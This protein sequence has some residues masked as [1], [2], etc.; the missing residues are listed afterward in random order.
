M[1]EMKRSFT[2]GK[3]N[4]DLDERLVPNGEYRDAMNVQV[5]TSEGSDV[6]TVQNV[7]GNVPGC[8]VDLTPNNSYTVGSVADEKNDTLYWLVSGNSGFAPEMKDMILRRKPDLVNGGYTCEPV[9]V[10]K[11]AFT[12]PNSENTDLDSLTVYAPG[13]LVNQVY[14]GWTATGV[15][16][17][18]NLSN[19]VTI[20]DVI[21]GGNYGFN[22]TFTTSNTPTYNSWCVGATVNPLI[23]CGAS[24]TYIPMIPAFGGGFFLDTSSGV[25]IANYTGD[26]LSGGFID[27]DTPGLGGNG[28]FGTGGNTYGYQ[29]TGENVSGIVVGGVGTPVVQLTLDAPLDLNP[30]LQGN[31]PASFIDDAGQ[32]WFVVD[33]SNITEATPNFATIPNSGII[34][35]PNIPLNVLNNMNIGDPVVLD[36]N[37]PYEFSGCINAVD[38]TI[39]PATIQ[40]VDCDNPAIFAEPAVLIPYPM[41]TYA[42]IGNIQLGNQVTFDF[43]QVD[44]L[45]SGDTYDSIVL[46]GPRVLNYDHDNLILGVNIIDDFLFW[47]DNKTEPKK[48]NIPRSVAGTDPS[49]NVHTDVM[50]PDASDNIT[51]NRGP[52]REQHITVIKKAP[53]RPPSLKM[54]TEL[55]GGNPTGE[56]YRLQYVGGNIFSAVGEVLFVKINDVDGIPCDFVVGDILGVNDGTNAVEG[57]EFADGY[58]VRLK[59]LEVHTGPYTNVNPGGPYG[60]N[61]FPQGPSLLGETAYLV[62]IVSII[63]DGS[64]SLAGPLEGWYVQLQ[65]DGKFLFEHKMPRF[66]YRYKYVD[67][68]YSTY[69]PFSNVAFAGGAFEYQPVKAY[70]EGMS[71]K[72]RALTIQDFVPSDIPEDV[73]QVDI[74]YKNENSPI[75][76]LM[77]SIKELDTP[78]LNNAWYATGS[79]GVA[80]AAKG[81]YEITTEN[82]YAALPANQLLRTWDNVP[83]TALAQDIT[84][85]RIVYGNY[86]QGYSMQ[87]IEVGGN[88]IPDINVSLSERNVIEGE[89]AVKSIKSLRNYDIGV[90]WGDKYGRET[91]VITPSS[92]S[93]V[94]PKVEASSKNYLVAS[95]EKS[96]AWADYYRYYI[97]ETSN[98]YYNLAVDRIYDA[99]DGNIWVSFPSID[100]NKVDED[101][102]IILKK[103]SD[104]DD[105]VEEKA[106]YKIVAIENEAPEYI[107]T[108]FEILAR[109]NTDTTTYEYSCQLFGGQLNLAANGNAGSDGAGNGCPIYPNPLGHITP[110]R[111]GRKSFTIDKKHWTD[112]YSNSPKRMGLPD[113][114]KVFEDVNADNTSDE[115]F[116]SFTKETST[117]G[118]TTTII[119]G[120]KYRV[121][122]IITHEG[123]PGTGDDGDANLGTTTINFDN[124]PL[125]PGGTA[126]DTDVY[127][128][129]LSTPI[130]TTDEFV[131]EGYNSVT[132]HL[133]PDFIHIH[134]WKKSIRNKPEFDG[135]FFVKIY[136]DGN[137]RKNLQQTPDAVKNWAIAASTSLFK[138]DD[139]TN[140]ADVADD[141]FNFNTGLTSDTAT[142]AQWGE[143]LKFG[144]ANVTSNWFIDNASFASQQPNTNNDFSNVV[145]L[146]TD[147]AGT[148]HES[149]DTTSSVSYNMVST[150]AFGGLGNTVG[151]GNL[152]S[153]GITPL[154]FGTGESTGIVGT[155]GAHTTSGGLYK[156][157]DFSYSSFDQSPPSLAQGLQG[158]TYNTNLNWAIGELGQNAATDDE[159]P[160]VE[161]L[162]PNV[163]FRLAGAETIYKIIG[164][165]K[166]RLFN[167]QG[168]KT[169][170]PASSSPG[171]YWNSAHMQQMQDMA[172]KTNRRYTFRIHYD[173]DT[174]NSPA[175]TFTPDPGGNPLL[176]PDTIDTG[177]T[178]VYGNTINAFN[179]ITNLVV[180]GAQTPGQIEFLVEYSVDGE[181][182]ISSN[183]AIFETEPKEDA[184]LDL[185]Y[186]ASSSFPTF[187]IT[188]SNRE[189]YLPIGS[190][191]EV[192]NRINE[193][194]EGA[195]PGSGI[196]QGIFVS[197]WQTVIPPAPGASQIVTIDLSTPLTITQFNALSAEQSIRFLRD[198]GTYVTAAIN[199]GT[200]GQVQQPDGSLLNM[201]VGLNIIPLNQVGLDWHN[202]WSFGNGVESNRIGDTYNK[203]FLLN[204]VSV[205]SIIE[206]N[207]KKEHKKY[208]LTYSGLYNSNSGVNNLNQFIA[209]EK[210]TKDLNPSYGSIQRLK[211]G[212]GQGGDLLALCEDRILKILANKDA[213]FN[214]DG[215]TNVTSTN[216]VLGQAIPYS[217]EY[218]ISKNPESFASEAYRAYF[219]DKVRGAVMR[220]SMDG[221]TA[222][223]EAGMKDW[224]R[225]NLKLN[226][227]LVGSYDDK[228]DEYNLSLMT[229]TENVSKTVTFKEDVRGWV[230][231]KSFVTQNGVSCA[232]DYFTFHGGTLWLHNDEFVDR[233][234]FYNVFTSSSFNV[235]LNDAPDV[236][237]SFYT[238]NYEGSKS[239]VE[240]NTSDDQYFNTHAFHVRDGWYVDHIFT[241]KETGDIEKGFI[242]KE[243]K[244]FNYIKGSDIIH[245]PN[246]SI[247][248]DGD[249][250]STWDGG[251]FAIQGLGAANTVA[252]P[253]PIFGCIDPTANNFDPTANTD[254]GSCTY[255]TGCT[256][257]TSV[258]YDATASIEDGSCTW[259]GCTDPSAS[260][261]TSFGAA[262]YAYNLT[263][264][265]AIIDD[266]SCITI[267]NG[268]TDSTAYNY[269][270][271]ATN[272]DGSC[273]YITMGCTE[274]LA[275]NYNPNANTNNP[276]DPCVFESCQANNN[277]I[278]YN[279][280][281]ESAYNNYI[282]NVDPGGILLNVC[283]SAGCTDPT[284]DNY[285]SGINYQGNAVTWDDGSCTYTAAGCT[286]PNSCNYDPTATVDDGSC[287]TPC[288][289]NDCNGVP[290]PNPIS[291]SYSAASNGLANGKI[292]IQ[293]NA[294]FFA[295][296]VITCTNCPNPG[297]I[298]ANGD[299]VFDNLPGG[300]T[301]TIEVT[302][303]IPGNTCVYTVT[304]IIGN[305]NYGCTD[306]TT[307]DGCGNGCNGANNYDASA[308]IDD[309]SCT[310]T[311]LCWGCNAQGIF[312]SQVFNDVN[313]ENADFSYDS[314]LDHGN[315]Q[316]SDV[317]YSSPSLVA[318]GGYSFSDGILLLPWPQG[319]GTLT[320][321]Q[322]GQYGFA[323][324]N[325]AL[326][327]GGCTDPGATNFDP[328]ANTDDGS[329]VWVVYGNS[330]G[331]PSIDACQVINYD[332]GYSSS[333]QFDGAQILT[334]DDALCA[335]CN[336][337]ANAQTN[338]EDEFGNLYTSC[339]Q[340]C[341]NAN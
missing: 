173:I 179:D 111:V 194:L 293:E 162:K 139:S 97:K 306:N 132:G 58:Q 336:D 290:A 296:L 277:D 300:V 141:V 171:F 294:S 251:S 54:S 254:D 165:I 78:L 109:T 260:N 115:F 59:V 2:K 151:F 332:P 248:V 172:D 155:K 70:N 252:G 292:I 235:I 237:K 85:N 15:T 136:S 29:I 1:P 182:E 281:A 159:A 265:G 126:A 110:P 196:Q 310:Y 12:I 177:Y 170:F 283:L 35:V 246:D 325:G 270:P 216:R 116:V 208:S 39:Y 205:S 22:W 26:P 160:I 206:D 202:C 96:P 229:T 27:I 242:E 46:Q 268:C 156:K 224:F 215:D 191:M 213:L 101:T 145:T 121:L 327:A 263:Y 9:F 329:C 267:V 123:N 67:N 24:S 225:D 33:H 274:P 36:V 269:N 108:N 318:A 231:F 21:S 79:V 255:N 314:T 93:L 49:G 77:D 122:D 297:Y 153:L 286:D 138:I 10:D 328:V 323:T 163:R 212:W 117:P 180:G 47:T 50:L 256:E 192:P 157:L 41:N 55:R 95:L 5:M 86:T 17:N 84:G 135:R 142:K 114:K 335:C 68:E 44:L 42:Q 125:T 308:N 176:T 51:I 167:Y 82:I 253:S 18:G 124:T 107:K 330:V 220:L 38:T 195:L 60:I 32:G 243:G 20:A 100:R 259:T 168:K 285:N 147:N 199:S 150:F 13:Q 337:P 257:S 148:S 130:L 16:A 234:T 228:K 311:A 154:P 338:I 326:C 184:D 320:P 240:Q 189:V 63:D 322:Y 266:G 90:V 278:N 186:E 102:Y 119:A 14:S 103:G 280:A 226:N 227:K 284:A 31:I 73:V 104:T 106:R 207:F 262:A 305:N 91:P 11:Y 37:S 112:T 258:D 201:I 149:V 43:A 64:V 128:I 178:D 75:V 313:D 81:S 25:Y 223:S 40:V 113:L 317:C 72:L 131:T 158:K 249:G 299:T 30:S 315:Q 4:K 52:A 245:N 247:K 175:G 174:V 89:F 87:D 250:G 230:S 99:E 241:N 273:I 94:V 48:I 34:E 340:Y 264:P 304:Q 316:L 169:A 261:T 146:F 88:L 236:V 238:L 56:G 193:L 185:Y 197:S 7:L 127:E 69:G 276:S 272:D 6:G 129:R 120:S 66:A 161:N 334:I 210:I 105:L 218:G 200:I 301:Y 298:D 289:W 309:G 219:T 203:T 324:L 74:L 217:G 198:D 333:Y 232:N 221:L 341:G 288:D 233:N 98:Q 137:D 331:D 53:H 23:P 302:S 303:G 190:T 239:K 319:N 118:G 57:D 211:A 271:A 295:P 214:A 282:A 28:Y 312:E 307:V 291:K 144:G 204:G 3:M 62:E 152:L 8:V 140:L 209:G 166:L 181:N 76:Y 287:F 134:F 61:G 187:P 19:S 279:P 222:I 65:D 143:L 244:W 188:N 92:G 133:G 275:A 339:A 80:G 71:N 83:I 183:P 321:T 164:V 45:L